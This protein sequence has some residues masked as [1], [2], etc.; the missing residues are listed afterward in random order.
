M[1]HDGFHGVFPYL[2]SPIDE[3]GRVKEPALTRLVN[4]LIDAGLRVEEAGVV[5]LDDPSGKLHRDR[6]V[7]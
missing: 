2:V 6:L 3:Q 4:D 1:T 5:P 7:G